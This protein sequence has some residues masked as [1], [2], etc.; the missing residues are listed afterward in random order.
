MSNKFEQISLK[1]GFMKHNGGVMF[2][3]IS[4]SEYEFKSSI[5]EKLT[6]LSK[7]F[8]VVKL[9]K[10]SFDNLLSCS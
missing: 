7:I 6:E 1:T 9:S 4:D 3:N 2:R 10:C 8:G 5:N